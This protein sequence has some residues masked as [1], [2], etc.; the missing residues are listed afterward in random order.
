MTVPIQFLALH[1]DF[2]ARLAAGDP[3]VVRPLSRL[4]GTTGAA[5]VLGAEGRPARYDP[6]ALATSLTVRLPGWPVLATSDGRGDHPY[7]AARRFLSL[8]HLSRGRSGVVFRG[9]GASAEHTAERIRVIRALWNS[10]PLE[11]LVADRDTGVYAQVD[12]IRA[13]DHEGV[14]FRVYGALNSPASIQGEP[15]TV[16]HI[17]TAAELDAAHGLVDLVVLDRPALL[18]RWTASPEDGR[19][20]LVAVGLNHNGA[21][22]GELVPVRTSAE[23]AEAAADSTTAARGAAPT[24]RAVLGLPVRSYDLSSKPFAFGVPSA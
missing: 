12:G 13:I 8:D 9:D 24:L 5:L 7:N 3:D 6:A 23:L 1:G 20:G 15:V 14:D 2:P 21:A 4:T 22:V 17:T 11:S 18:E 19:P 10:W 16:W